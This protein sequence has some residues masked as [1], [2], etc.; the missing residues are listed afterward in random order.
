MKKT[1]FVAIW[2]LS[3]LM[4]MPVLAQTKPEPY[5]TQP[6]FTGTKESRQGGAAY[7]NIY[8]QLHN[9]NPL[10]E[11]FN[12]KTKQKIQ[13]IRLTPEKVIHCNNANFGPY[14]MKGDKF[15]L[16]Y[17]SSERDQRIDVYRVQ[18]NGG[19][20]SVKKIQ[21]IKLPDKD[22]ASQYFTNLILDN[23][24]KTVWITG[25]TRNFWNKADDGN[26]LRY[27]QLRLPKPEDGDVSLSYEDRV[28]E[29][30]LPFYIATQGA[31][32]HKG[33]IHQAFGIARG[34][35]NIFRVINPHTGTIEQ[36]YT[37]YGVDVHEEPE[38]A[39]FYKGKPMVIT[40]RGNHY[41]VK[42]FK[43]VK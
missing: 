41:W 8:F 31:F 29:F 33:K 42:D 7:K 16:L 34:N 23:K 38:A 10:I 17:I 1:T 2:A 22:V 39:I 11:I 32:L 25:Y 20:Y 18:E 27:I 12:L 13:E 3:A 28:S 40:V 9:A 15:P 35:D 19:V 14:K 43:R 36:E 24:N 4:A 21:T 37:M 30:Y 5:M 26:Q 6:P